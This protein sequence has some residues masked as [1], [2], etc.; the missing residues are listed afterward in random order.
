LLRRGLKK[1][2]GGGMVVADVISWINV[3]STVNSEDVWLLVSSRQGGMLSKFMSLLVKSDE[4]EE[5]CIGPVVFCESWIA[6]S[7]T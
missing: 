4:T 3:T 1:E 6:V 5:L 7:V 2:G